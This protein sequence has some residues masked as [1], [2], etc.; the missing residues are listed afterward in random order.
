MNIGEARGEARIV[1]RGV[2]AGLAR[3]AAVSVAGRRAGN[4]DA[5]L[6]DERL[7]LFAVADGLGGYEGGALASAMALDEIAS[8][9]RAMSED[10]ERTWPFA[11]DPALSPE[12]NVLEQAIR[13]AHRTVR[14]GQVAGLTRMATTVA[15]LRVVGEAVVIGHVGDSRV[16]RW[17]SGELKALTRDHSMVEELRA[18]G[19]IGEGETPRHFAHVI[20]RALGVEGWSRATMRQSRWRRGDR[21]LLCSDGLHGWLSPAEM[22][23]GLS[24]GAA[25]VVAESLV[26]E[27]IAAGSTDNV[28]AVVVDVDAFEGGAG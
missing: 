13:L 12:A 4:E 9:L 7:G 20:T 2:R 1:G 19:A 3:G 8:Y 27:A 24:R 21:Y 28:S 6:V 15:A 10:A 25:R 14:E 18:A 26:H 5:V 11:A 17:R 16:Y 23:V 22:A